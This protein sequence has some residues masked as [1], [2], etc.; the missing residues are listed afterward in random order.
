MLA[1]V[2][3]EEAED[4]DRC[5][6][7]PARMT[8]AEDVRAGGVEAAEVVVILHWIRQMTP[9]VTTRI[10]VMVTALTRIRR[11]VRKGQLIL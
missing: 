5:C 4:G 2:A 8:S 3:V 10:R 11:T 1:A 6:S 7:F 9:I